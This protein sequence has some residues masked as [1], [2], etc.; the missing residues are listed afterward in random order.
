MASPLFTS[1][2]FTNLNPTMLLHLA[3]ACTGLL[4]LFLGLL[5][6]VLVP[7]SSRAHPQVLFGERARKN[8]LGFLVAGVLMLTLWGITVALPHFPDRVRST[9]MNSRSN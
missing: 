4:L 9:R 6:L 1:F 5:A 2:Q 7:F 3:A 8:P